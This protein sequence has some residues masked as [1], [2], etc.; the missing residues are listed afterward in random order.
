MTKALEDGRDKMGLKNQFSIEIFVC[1]FDN[2]LK[3]V[4]FSLIYLTFFEN[5]RV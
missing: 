1:K 3:I 2:V 4:Y 5:F